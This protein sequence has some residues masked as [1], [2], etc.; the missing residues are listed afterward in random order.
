MGEP[1]AQVYFSVIPLRRHLGVIR[2]KGQRMRAGST[3]EQHDRLT[4]HLRLKDCLTRREESSS[5]GE[6]G[7]PEIPTTSTRNQMRSGVHDDHL[8][9]V[10]PIYLPGVTTR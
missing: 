9:E 2:P 5:T 8:A 10:L 1:L 4:P 7:E 6:K 3:D